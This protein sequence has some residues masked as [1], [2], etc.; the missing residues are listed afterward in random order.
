MADFTYAYSPVCREHAR[1][2]FRDGCIANYKEETPEDFS[3]VS[4]ITKEK[5]AVG[6]KV[7]MKCSFGKFGAPLLVFSNDVSSNDDGSKLYGL[8]FEVVA[9]ENGCNIWHIVPDPA[10]TERPIRTKKI[11]FAEFEIVPDEIIEV[12]VEFQQGGIVSTI[13]GHQLCCQNEDF[14]EEFYVG[15][16]GCEGPNCFYELKIE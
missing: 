11:A 10:N 3:Y 9:Y 2:E 16:T 7:S 13:N 12:Q 15:I 14:P 6:A 4:L 8:H 5:C 1:F